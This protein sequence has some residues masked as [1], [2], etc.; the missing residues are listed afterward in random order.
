MKINLVILINNDVNLILLI[1]IIYQTTN[2]FHITVMLGKSNYICVNKFFFIIIFTS[3]WEYFFYLLH[4]FDRTSEYSLHLNLPTSPFHAVITALSF[5]HSIPNCI[6]KS[7]S[8][9]IL[10]PPWKWYVLIF[11]LYNWPLKGWLIE[12]IKFIKFFAPNNFVKCRLTSLWCS[13]DKLGI[14]PRTV[15]YSEDWSSYH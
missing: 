8:H 11:F 1:Y 9:H 3:V 7:C 10:W 12:E 2:V 5:I 15:W 14:W 6:K 4:N 13:R